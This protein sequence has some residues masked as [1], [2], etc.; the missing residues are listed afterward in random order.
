MCGTLSF[1]YIRF[2]REV[3]RCVGTFAKTKTSFYLKML[4]SVFLDI[5]LFRRHTDTHTK[6]EPQ[7]LIDIVYTDFFKCVGIVPIP[8]IQTFFT[9]LY[10]PLY[11]VYTPPRI[12]HYL[13]RFQT[14]ITI[15]QKSL[16]FAKKYQFYPFRN[17]SKGWLVDLGNNRYTKRLTFLVF[18]GV[19]EQTV[20]K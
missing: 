19:F 9:P 13:V 15:T 10:N 18:F 6:T 17:N 2:S 12:K 20:F 5:Y 3:C 7:T 1:V 8:H 4:V 14:I 11:I 16:L